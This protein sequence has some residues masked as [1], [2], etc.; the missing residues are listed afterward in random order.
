MIDGLKEFV[1]MIKDFILSLINGLATLV[2]SLAHISGISSQ[3][4]W[5]MPS[6]LFS[7]MILSLTII[8]VL[9]VIGR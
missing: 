2:E 3:A 9:R 8:I 5:W 6:A 1:V 4:A 7:V